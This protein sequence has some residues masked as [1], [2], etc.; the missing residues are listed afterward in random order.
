MCFLHAA[1]VETCTIYCTLCA[2]APFHTPQ[3]PLHW[4][5]NEIS[6]PANRFIF[7]HPIVDREKHTHKSVFKNRS[8]ASVISSLGC[9][10]WGKTG[11]L[12]W[13]EMHSLP[14]LII[15]AAKTIECLKQASNSERRIRCFRSFE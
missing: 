5:R 13:S 7:F 10:S 2:C 4:E 1:C 14:K 9:G 3:Q 8:K 11:A 12:F 15:A 6:G